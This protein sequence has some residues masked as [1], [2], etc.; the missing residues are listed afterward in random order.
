MVSSDNHSLYQVVELNC[1]HLE[2]VY[3]IEKLSFTDPWSR[4]LFEDELINDKSVYYVILNNSKVIGYC[5][6]WVIL[7]EIDIMNI[8]VHPEY[9]RTGLGN[10]LMDVII[11]YAEAYRIPYIT[12]EVRESN[13]AALNLYEKYAFKRAGIRKG[14]YEDRENA[15]IMWR[16]NII[17]A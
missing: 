11:G 3:E 9:R 13:T 10:M 4:K 15:V 16:T 1:S 8:A 12:L 7:D 2:E 6:F 5:G 14:Y 17:K